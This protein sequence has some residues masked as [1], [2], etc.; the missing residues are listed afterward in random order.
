MLTGRREPPPPPPVKVGQKTAETPY[1]G[2]DEK[3]GPHPCVV[4][5]VHPAHRW[6]RVRFTEFGFCQ[7]YKY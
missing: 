7:A 1:W 2:T 5:F 4:E 6:Y 3:C